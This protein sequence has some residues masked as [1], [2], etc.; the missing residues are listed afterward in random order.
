MSTPADLAFVNGA[1]Y[2]VDAASSWAR[3]VAVRDGRIVAVGTDDDVREHIGAATEVLD[4]AGKM[5]LPGFQDAHVHAQGGGIDRLRVD[6]SE[7]HSADDYARV[8]RTYADAN[9][10]ADWILGGG[11]AMD[12]FPGGN[13]SR[14]QLDAIV[15]DRPAFFAN[16]DN[17]AAWVN[18]RA[19]EIAGVDASTPDPVDGRIEREADGGPQGTLHEGA[20]TY[21]RRCVPDPDDETKRK[22]LLIAQAYLHSLGITA[23]QEAIVGDYPTVPNARDVYPSLAGRGDLTGKV[24]GALWLERGRGAEQVDELVGYRETTSI[25]AYRATTVKIMLD[26]VCENFTAAM[27]RSYLGEDGRETGNTGIEYFDPETLREVLIR[28]DAEGFQAH[29]HVIGDRACHEALDAIGAARAA[30]GPSDNRHHLA[31]VQLVQPDDVARF[32][33]LDVTANVQMLWAAHEPQQDELTAPFI[34]EER[35]GWQYPFGSLL[36]AGATMCAGSDWP[37]STPDPLQEMHVG[38]HRTVPPGYTYGEANDD[39]FIPEQRI[40][41]AQAIRSFT[42]GSAYV[43]HLDGLTGSIE[44]GKAADVVVLSED[45][46]AVDSPTDARVLLTVADGHKVFE[47]DGSGL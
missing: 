6:M 28:L 44:V 1:V 36:A 40:T 27:T 21:V 15:P 22:A 43:N 12:I 8:I 11:W 19:L 5:L 30:N 35:A 10:D 38:V 31:H 18:T 34:G 37:V 47:A 29:I 14:Q 23:W 2:T 16:R 17:H 4:L 33:D 41:L 32:R 3:A 7:V 26:G 20:M 46:F 39:V 45:L 9:P 42:M 24:V 25:G 13:P